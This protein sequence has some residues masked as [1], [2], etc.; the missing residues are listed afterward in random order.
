MDRLGAEIKEHGAP[1]ADPAPW[2]ELQGVLAMLFMSRS[3]SSAIARH[4][5]E[6]F[7]CGTVREALNLPNLV[8]QK[9]RQGAA[10]LTEALKRYVADNGSS[11]WFAFKAA[12]V[13][14]A[15]GE[16]TGFTERY[17]HLSSYLLL[18]R[19][20]IIAQAV[21]ITMARATGRYHSNQQE[22][23]PLTDDDFKPE[24]ILQHMQEIAQGTERLRRYITISGRPWRAVLY[25]TFD[26][27]DVGPIGQALRYLGLPERTQSRELGGRPLERVTR[28]ENAVWIEKVRDAL[29]DE[30][31]ALVRDYEEFVERMLA[32]SAAQ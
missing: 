27:G 22:R 11:G 29:D 20:D 32:E 24:Q 31:R 1:P 14:L 4:I 28:T 17:Q 6:N 5:S 19:R 12:S 16:V 21:S 9:E 13:G 10:D 2:P 25:E 26:D 18:M 15:S 23:R 7:D 3:G 8:T 30:G